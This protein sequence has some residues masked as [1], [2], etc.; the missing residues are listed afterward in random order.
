M[1]GQTMSPKQRTLILILVFVTLIVGSFIWFIVSWDPAR[2]EPV[3]FL[4]KV[5]LVVPT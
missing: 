4:P 2:A 3:T 5:K 1:E